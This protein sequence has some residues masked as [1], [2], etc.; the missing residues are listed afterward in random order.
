M[1]LL[2]IVGCLSAIALTVLVVRLLWIS[3][4]AWRVVVRVVGVFVLMM[5]SGM[6]TLVVTGLALIFLGL[7]RHDNFEYYEHH[8]YHLLVF[9]PAIATSLITGYLTWIF[10][11]T[12]QG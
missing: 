2:T 6:A 9:V 8:E 7:S 11:R 5:A 10:T 4:G 12:K 1:R 3:G